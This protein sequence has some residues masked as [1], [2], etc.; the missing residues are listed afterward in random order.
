[1]RQPEHGPG[2]VAHPAHPPSSIDDYEC[3]LCTDLLYEPVVAPCG[4]VFCRYA[5]VCVRPS[6]RP[7]VRAGAGLC[8]RAIYACACT[9]LAWH[10]VSMLAM[11]GWSVLSQA[12]A[13]QPSPFCCESTAGCTLFLLG[14][15]GL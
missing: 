11:V 4:H 3:A 6:V 12:C 8:A 14:E 2:S 13:L 10:P 7:S 1:M 9:G 15:A 5:C